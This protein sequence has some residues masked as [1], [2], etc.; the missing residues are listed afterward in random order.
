MQDFY[1]NTWDVLEQFSHG[2]KMG[3]NVLAHN[4]TKEMTR[5]EIKFALQVECV[6]NQVPEPEYRELIVEVAFCAKL[7]LF[8]RNLAII[9]L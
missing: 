3:E 6:L 9:E 4:L 5:R 7:L 8:S 2:I 1:A